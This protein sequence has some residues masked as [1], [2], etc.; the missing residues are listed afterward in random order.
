MP[1]TKATRWARNHPFPWEVRWSPVNSERSS[2]AIAR[3]AVQHGS[4]WAFPSLPSLVLCPPSL[5]FPSYFTRSWLCTGTTLDDFQTQIS[6]ISWV[7]VHT[8]K[9]SACGIHVIHMT[10]LRYICYSLRL[11][12]K[13]IEAQEANKWAHSKMLIR[14]ETRPFG[15]KAYGHIHCC[16]LSLRSCCHSKNVSR[17]NK[18]EKADVQKGKDSKQ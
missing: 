8:S 17:G 16:L 9:P 14:G 4:R 6:I 7:L 15:F 1:V 3:M 5:T 13:E 2:S 10:T 12:H 18:T 11:L